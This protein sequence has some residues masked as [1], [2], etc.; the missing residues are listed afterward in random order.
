MKTRSN[1]SKRK[2]MAFYIFVVSI[3]IFSICQKKMQTEFED[4]SRVSAELIFQ[5]GFESSSSGIPQ[6]AHTKIVGKDNSVNQPNDWVADLDDHPNIGNFRFSYGGGDVSGRYIRIIPDPTSSGNQVLHYWLKHPNVQNPPG[7]FFKKRGRLQANIY[8]RAK[9]KKPYTNLMEMYQKCRMYI[10]PDFDILKDYT[11]R[12]TWLTIAELWN[13]ATGWT[14]ESY[15]FRIA[16]NI[17]KESGTGKD[18]HFNVTGE[19]HIDLK[20]VFWSKSNTDFVV[21]TGEWLTSEIYFKEGDESSGRFYFAL[22]R[23]NGNKTVIVDIYNR[24]CHPDDPSP[25]GLAHWDPLKLYTSDINVDFVR[26]NGGVLQIY[27]DDFSLWKG[28]ARNL[29]TTVILGDNRNKTENNVWSISN[30]IWNFE[31]KIDIHD[32]RG[33]LL[34]SKQTER[35]K[36]PRQKLAP[37]AYIFIQ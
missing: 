18:F 20:K 13:N 15:P 31:N 9:H 6:S 22:Q 36:T 27:W 11:G 35:S 28:D 1:I 12:I 4:L 19:D 23:E 29:S 25:D 3:T 7:S 21:P 33:R 34:W 26:N 14:G 10:H 17:T 24:T 32:I 5:S 37:G 8:R 16:I 30:Y 2:W